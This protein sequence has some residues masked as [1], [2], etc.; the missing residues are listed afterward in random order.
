MITWS[1]FEDMLQNQVLLSFYQLFKFSQKL[2][3][4]V[5][6]MVKQINKTEAY[7]KN[8]VEPLKYVEILT[9]IPRKKNDLKLTKPK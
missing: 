2:V 7:R 5:F 6:C 1:I 4:Q 8:S 9:A 3:F